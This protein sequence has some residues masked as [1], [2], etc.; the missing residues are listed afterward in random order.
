[1]AMTARYVID[2][3]PVRATRLNA[4]YPGIYAIR[5]NDGPILGY[6]Q[7]TPNGVSEA[8]VGA[9]PPDAVGA[10]YVGTHQTMRYAVAQLVRDATTDAESRVNSEVPA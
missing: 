3:Q 4:G 6:V 8:Y 5:F 9:V 2:G 7:R 1:M 10:Q